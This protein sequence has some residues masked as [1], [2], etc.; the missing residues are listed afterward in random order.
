MKLLILHPEL[1]GRLRILAKTYPNTPICLVSDYGPIQ[2]PSAILCE[3]ACG[4]GGFVL[5]ELARTR[6]DVSVIA[7]ESVLCLPETVTD[8]FAHVVYSTKLSAREIK[9]MVR[10]MSEHAE[11]TPEPDTTC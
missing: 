6:P 1:S 11:L 5:S 7:C 9:Y 8:T 4:R 2:E 3:E 10:R